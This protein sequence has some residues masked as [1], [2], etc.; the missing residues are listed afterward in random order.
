MKITNF[1]GIS[2]NIKLIYKISAILLVFIYFVFHALSGENGLRAYLVTKNQLKNQTEKLEKIE[3][4]LD[5]LKRNVRLLSSESLDLDLLEER[6]RIILNYSAQ[7]DVI[8]RSK[9]ILNG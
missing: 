4:A 1:V 5:S 6:C 3:Y 8:I 7:D 9:S 2:N